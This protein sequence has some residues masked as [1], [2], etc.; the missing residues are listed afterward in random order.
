MQSSLIVQE[1]VSQWSTLSRFLPSTFPGKYDQDVFQV[2]IQSSLVSMGLIAIAGGLLLG[3]QFYA[4][5][6]L[7]FEIRT[8]AEILEELKVGVI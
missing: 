5:L 4:A 3:S 1:L 7:R 8:Q 6:R 2:T